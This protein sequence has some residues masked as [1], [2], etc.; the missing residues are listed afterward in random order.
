MGLWIKTPDGTLEKAAGAEGYYLP[1]AGGTV[2]GDLVVG[3][4]LTVGKTLNTAWA[5]VT[6]NLDVGAQL[7]VGG[8]LQV[9]GNVGFKISSSNAPGSEVGELK[10]GNGASLRIYSENDVQY[11]NRI[12]AFGS[13]LDMDPGCKLL[14]RGEAEIKGDLKVGS[15]ITVAKAG[16]QAV[17]N[18]DYFRAYAGSITTPAYSFAAAPHLGM[19]LADAGAGGMIGLSGNLH[20]SGTIYGTL[21]DG[22]RVAGN[23]QVDGKITNAEVNGNTA[24]LAL[25]GI[26]GVKR[27]LQTDSKW[28]G[29]ATPAYRALTLRPNRRF[30]ISGTVGIAKGIAADAYTD[31]YVNVSLRIDNVVLTQQSAYMRQGDMNTYHLEWTGPALHNATGGSWQGVSLHVDS[32]VWMYVGSYGRQ[33]SLIIED[34][35]PYV[36]L[37]DNGRT[38]AELENPETLDLDESNGE[39]VELPDPLFGRAETATMPA[40]GEGEGEAT[41]R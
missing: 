14:V 37:N 30:R 9:Q 26:I 34:V 23:L 24:D 35:G 25:R 5:N 36:E 33:A 41:V 32:D 12:M 6:N 22:T 21:A 18:S 38:A 16:N 13:L 7:N 17:V 3:D 11:P 1:L 31:S 2:T 20:V 4:V 29:P 15:T 10:A 28:A 40:L 19:Y 8:D 39:P 27:G